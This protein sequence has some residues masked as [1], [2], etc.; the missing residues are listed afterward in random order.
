MVNR[1]E[2]PRGTAA[3]IAACT[4]GDTSVSL[5]WPRGLIKFEACRWGP[6]G[7]VEAPSGGPR[8][9]SERG[10]FIGGGRRGEDRRGHGR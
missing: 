7:G 9:E 6:E 1:G 2:I 10:R 4:G 5:P 8:N 3:C